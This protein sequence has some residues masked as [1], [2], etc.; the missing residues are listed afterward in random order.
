MRSLFLI[1]RRCKTI[2]KENLVNEEIRAKEVRL[3]DSEGNQ[4]GVVSIQ[5]ARALAEEQ[6]L[7]LVSIS[8]NAAPPVCKIMD[9]G[10]YHFEQQ[11]KEKEARKKQKVVEIK[12][13]RLGIFTEEHLVANLHIQGENLAVIG[14]L[15]VA[16]GDDFTHLRLFLG[17]VGDNQAPGGFGFLFDALD[18][19][20]ILKRSDV[21]VL[22]SFL[23]CWIKFSGCSR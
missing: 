16:G 7:D 9:Y 8:P 3:I 18:D 6:R 10:K 21:H 22:L 5:D 23:T 15:A 4:L 13:I 20:T 17:G 19:E 2:S 11:K 14:L 1:N 12:E